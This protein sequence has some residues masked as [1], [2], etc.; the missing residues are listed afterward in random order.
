MQV[1]LVGKAGGGGLGDRRAGFEQAAGGAN[2]VGDLQRV[3]W[4]PGSLAPVAEVIAGQA[5]RPVVAGAERRPLR[6]H[7]RG[8]L[9]QGAQPLSES[10]VSL[11]D[12]L[13]ALDVTLPA[14]AITRLEAAASFEVGFPSDF[15]AG[16]TGFVYGDAGALVDICRIP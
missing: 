13:G 2:A 4:Q 7:G 11:E 1:T 14:D 16:M 15:I 9:D 5:E 12:N 8:V 3:G 6:A 10:L